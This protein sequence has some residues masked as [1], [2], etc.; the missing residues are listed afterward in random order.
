MAYAFTFWTCYVLKRKYE[1]IA[2]EQRRPDQFTM[3]H[4]VEIGNGRVEEYGVYDAWVCVAIAS[5]L[6][7]EV[8]ISSCL[9]GSSF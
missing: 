3:N 2:S 1:I 7:R 6:P 9:L 4:K 5:S 8:V